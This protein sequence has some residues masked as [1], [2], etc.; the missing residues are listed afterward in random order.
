MWFEWCRGSHAEGPDVS[1][2]RGV[3]RTLRRSRPSHR[4]RPQGGV[5][6]L[7]GG[8]LFVGRGAVIEPN[9]VVHGPA[10]IGPRTRVRAGAYIRGDVVAGVGCVLRGELKNAL[11]LDGAELG[12]PGYCGDSLVG[13]RGHFAAQAC[14]ANLGL[15]P[16]TPSPARGAAAG[17][18]GARVAIGGTVYSLGRRKMGAVLGDGAQLG[19][20]AVTDPATF[21]APRTIVCVCCAFGPAIAPPPAA[22]EP[23]PEPKP[24]SRAVIHS[25]TRVR[26]DVHHLRCRW[27]VPARPPG[28]G[29]LWTG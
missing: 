4:Q 18:G 25:R 28:E 17:G 9:A 21:L 8:S 3:S 6:D 19:V 23:E 29:V 22:Y 13:H 11:L 24:T 15:L 2:K 10:V 14:T 7:T 12:H 27:Q 26:C 1:A 5:F 20:G 16:P